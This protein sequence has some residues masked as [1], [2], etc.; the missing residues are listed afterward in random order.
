MTKFVE[1][2]PRDAST[3]NLLIKNLMI[4]K[5]L[6]SKL[7]SDNLSHLSIDKDLLIIKFQKI[8]ISSLDIFE[9]YFKGQPKKLTIVSKLG[10]QLT[11]ELRRIFRFD[12]GNSRVESEGFS[13]IEVKQTI[14]LLKSIKLTIVKLKYTHKKI[15][16]SL[17]PRE[18]GQ[19]FRNSEVE[20][21]NQFREQINDGLKTLG[22]SIFRPNTFY[23]S[24][25]GAKIER[26]RKLNFADF[27]NMNLLK[28]NEISIEIASPKK[29]VKTD[30]LV[31]NIF[32]RSVSNK[33]DSKRQ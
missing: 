13:K 23:E 5:D 9:I 1:H 24:R 22:S 20:R 21:K 8:I 17:G 33:Y 11:F 6:L 19:V 15:R 3:T 29:K 25:N 16:A 4:L 14:H 27:Y 18:N 2:K 12:C 31:A 7:N 28:E 32:E 26:D 30:N 10:R